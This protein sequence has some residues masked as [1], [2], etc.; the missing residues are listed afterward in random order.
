[1]PAAPTPENGPSKDTY[2]LDSS[3]IF[4]Y[5]EAAEGGSRVR[6]LLKTERVMLPFVVALEVHYI[7]T[8]EKGILVAQERLAR[9]KTLPCTWLNTVDEET[10][11]AASRVKAAH[12]LSFADAI[13]AGFAIRHNAILVHK[14]PE[15]EILP[16][17]VRQERLPYKPRGNAP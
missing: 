16:G 15:F 17:E 12:R 3:G 7:T 2:L 11:L 6:D 9:L 5:L 8:Q 13:V 14:D 4:A 1:M 10:L